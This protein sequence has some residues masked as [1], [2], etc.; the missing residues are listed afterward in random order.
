VVIWVHESSLCCRV[1]CKGIY[2]CGSE[3][4]LVLYFSY[5]ATVTFLLPYWSVPS[6]YLIPSEAEGV[7][8]FPQRYASRRNPFLRMS[9]EPQAKPRQRKVQLLEVMEICRSIWRLEFQSWCLVGSSGRLWL[10]LAAAWESLES[11]HQ[12]SQS[13]GLF[14]REPG[15]GKRLGMYLYTSISHTCNNDVTRLLQRWQWL[16]S[17]A[18]Y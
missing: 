1:R 6:R 2:I 5:C 17:E 10:S 12:V 16:Q 7:Q 4:Q 18:D 11:F 15:S 8:T 13:G 3:I 14:P 9:N